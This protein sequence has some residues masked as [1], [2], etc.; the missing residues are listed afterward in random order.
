M[1]STASDTVA[2]AASTD[3][4]DHQSVELLLLLHACCREWLH[5]AGGL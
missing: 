3:V 4:V 5:S 1:N 2:A